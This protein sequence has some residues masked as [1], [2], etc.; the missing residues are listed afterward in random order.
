MI[1]TKDL[2]LGNIV[3]ENMGF[4]MKVVSIFQDEVYLNFDEHEGD[5]F[6]E[7][8]M[9]LNPVPITEELL[10]KIGAVKKEDRDFKSYKIAGM[11]INLIDGKW[12]EYV[13][14]IEVVGLH[15]LQNIFYFTRGE[16]LGIKLSDL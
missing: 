11:E 13:H 8:F 2:R 5:Y 3:N 16:E 6:E 12:I 7:D 14:R 10:A 9:K 4:A 15:T 1:R